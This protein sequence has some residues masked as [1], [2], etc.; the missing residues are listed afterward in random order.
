MSK[1]RHLSISH[2]PIACSPFE[3]IK[4]YGGKRATYDVDQVTCE[5]CL[6]IAAKLVEERLQP[7][8]T[9]RLHRSFPADLW[10]SKPDPKPPSKF[11]LS[12]GARVRII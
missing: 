4:P 10:R 7:F 2:L 1:L 5:K 12:L 9:G 11:D 6:E 8:D 3:A